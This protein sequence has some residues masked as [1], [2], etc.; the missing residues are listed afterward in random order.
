MFS[1]PVVLL[2]IEELALLTGAVFI[3]AHVHVSWWLF[4]LLFLAPDLFMLGYLANPRLG[5][6][7]DNLGHLLLVP[8]AL[9]FFGYTA[10]RPLLCAIG[11]IWSSH[12]ALDRLLGYGLKYPGEFKDTHLQHIAS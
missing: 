1:R 4:A 10:G 3:F 12:I 5:A 6:A 8:I 11:A 9:I 7:T 2:R